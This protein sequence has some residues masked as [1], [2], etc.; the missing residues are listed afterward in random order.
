M[1]TPSECYE[2]EPLQTRATCF[3]DVGA[4]R[5]KGV[6]GTVRARR[7]CSFSENYLFH[8]V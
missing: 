4:S 8:V 5:L 6:S 7:I 1:P 3:T 2:V